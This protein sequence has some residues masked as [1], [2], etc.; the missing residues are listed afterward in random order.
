MIEMLILVVAM[1]APATDE[2]QPIPDKAV[3][4]SGVCEFPVEVCI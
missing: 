2:I 3:C 4:E 1:T